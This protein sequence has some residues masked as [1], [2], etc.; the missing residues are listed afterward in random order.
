[1]WHGGRSR[2]RSPRG[3]QASFGAVD[4][5]GVP[6]DDIGAGGD[7]SQFGMMGGMGGMAM[8]PQMAA[9]QQMMRTMMGAGGN[10]RSQQAMMRQLMMR[11]FQQQMA[12]QAAQMGMMQQMMM[13]QQQVFASA[14]GGGCGEVC[15]APPPGDS[16]E[17]Q[18]QMGRQAYA[19]AVRAM[20]HREGESDDDVPTGPSSNV[21]HPN[22][23]PPNS[24]PLPGVTDQRFEGRF[25]LWFEEK[26]FGFIECPALKARFPNVDVFLYR[27]QKRHFVRGDKVTFSVFMNFKGHPQATELRR[28]REGEAPEDS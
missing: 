9:M 25:K 24:E 8:P 28:A 2:S 16:E 18:R 3:Q 10:S 5:E 12:A 20:N 26:G 14:M 15:P 4:E 21:N 1:M 23:R 22:Y 27:N 13:A 11:Q 19:N 7:G 17:T 6:E